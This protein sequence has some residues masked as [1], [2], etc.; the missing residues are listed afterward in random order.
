MSATAVRSVSY[1]SRLQKGGALIPEMRTLLLEWDDRAGTPQRI[2]ES[3]HLTSPSRARVRDVVMRTFIPRFVRSDPPN[4]WR[5][6]A[7]LERARWSTSALVPIHYYAAAAAEPILWDFVADVLAER[8]SRGQLDVTIGDAE[9]FL[10]AAPA[11]RFQDGRWTS[12]VTTKVARGLLAALR[13]FGVLTGAV[14]KRIAPLYL[15]TETF[16]FLAMVRHQLGGRG[17]AL[18]HDEVW[19]LFFLSDL[20]VERFFVEAHQ[21]KLLTYQAAGS[22]VSVSFPASTLEDCARELAEVAH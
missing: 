17:S 12:T 1:T 14:K 2:V 11:S 13:D 3:N 10:V 16:A 21:R 9:R 15:P 4:L 6:L 22:L 7:I 19:R 5:P 8:F 20:A 18:L